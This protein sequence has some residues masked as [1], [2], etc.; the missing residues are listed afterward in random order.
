[1]PMTTFLRMIAV[2]VV[3][4]TTFL[5][6]VAVVGVAFASAVFATLLLF[7]ALLPLQQFHLPFEVYAGIQALMSIA[8]AFAFVFGG[9]MV[10]PR[11][12]R[13]LAAFFLLVIGIACFLCTQKWDASDPVWSPVWDLVL[14]AIGGL[15]AV[16]IQLWR[17]RKNASQPS[18]PPNGGPRVPPVIAAV[19]G[20]PPSVS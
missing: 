16:R 11:P 7:V 19:A 6:M 5:R 10:V 20:G 1:M 2:V 15:I 12:Q 13:V 14:C 9:S 8:M 17:A 4:M 3:P 18:A